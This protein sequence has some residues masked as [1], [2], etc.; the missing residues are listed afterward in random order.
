MLAIA[1]EQVDGK[2][3]FTDLYHSN[4]RDRGDYLGGFS[5]SASYTN[6]LRNQKQRW[7]SYPWNLGWDYRFR[8]FT[9]MGSSSHYDTYLWF[10][11]D[12]SVELEQF[13]QQDRID[14]R[15][16]P[17]RVLGRWRRSGWWIC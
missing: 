2:C 12:S 15:R 16:L 3:H 13:Q 8:Y 6:R 17:R 9:R 1:K 5:R 10:I 11:V 7:T 14:R 4:W